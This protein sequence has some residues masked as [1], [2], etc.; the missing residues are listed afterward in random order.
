MLEKVAKKAVW[1]KTLDAEGGQHVLI[2]VCGRFLWALW[3][4]S[5]APTHCLPPLSLTCLLTATDDTKVAG[6]YGLKE[7]SGP[8]HSVAIV[9][10]SSIEVP[11][12][13]LLSSL[14]KVGHESLPGCARPPTAAASHSLCVCTCTCLV[15]A[16]VHH[17]CVHL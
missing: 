1:T 13:D 6:K 3:R 8:V 10:S 17:V 14:A 16:C 12:A 2:G 4:L 7:L 15:Y 11:V 5:A 9:G